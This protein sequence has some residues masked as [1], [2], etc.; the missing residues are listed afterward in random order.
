MRG[1]ALAV[2][3]LALSL[4]ASKWESARKANPAAA[5]ACKGSAKKAAACKACCA[6]AGA[7]GHM[8]MTSSGCKCF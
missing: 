6:A 4:G 3:A 5:E 1:L 2:V 8:F 7:S